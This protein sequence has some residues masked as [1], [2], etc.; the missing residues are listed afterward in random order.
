[1]GQEGSQRPS[2]SI[3]CPGLVQLLHQLPKVP[4]TALSTPQGLGHP[5]LSAC[6]HSRGSAASEH[7]SRPPLAP[8][9]QLYVFLMM[10]SQHDNSTNPPTTI[11]RI[12]ADHHKELLPLQSSPQ[13]FPIRS[14]VTQLLGH[15]VQPCVPPA[16]TAP[17]ALQLLLWEL[18]C[19]ELLDKQANPAHGI[20][21]G[22]TVQCSSGSPCLTHDASI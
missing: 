6:A 17:R 5:Q 20:R 3:P 4:S 19:H 10:G 16:L 1:M 22:D 2:S 12:T 21:P 15:T 9:Q 11:S 14:A 7:P 13:I 18:R 8:P